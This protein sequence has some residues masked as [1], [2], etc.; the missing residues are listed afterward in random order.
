MRSILFVTILSLFSVSI[1]GQ[2]PDK[3]SDLIITTSKTVD[4][5]TNYFQYFGI[6]NT[7]GLKISPISH[8]RQIFKVSVTAGTDVE[9]LIR[10]IKASNKALNVQYDRL[11]ELRS[12]F[13]YH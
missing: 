2:S 3:L 7:E 11:L 4:H 5:K 8:D 13:L 1:F 6:P 9:N 10:N 12:E